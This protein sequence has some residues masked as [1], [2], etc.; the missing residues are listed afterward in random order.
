[1]RLRDVWIRVVNFQPCVGLRSNFTPTFPH[2]ENKLTDLH[3]EIAPGNLLKSEYRTDKNWLSWSFHI[4]GTRWCVFAKRRKLAWR[5]GS[6]CRYC[7]RIIKC[8]ICCYIVCCG[9]V[10]DDARNWKRNWF[11]EWQLPT[12][13][14]N[15]RSDLIFI[16]DEKE[17]VFDTHL[18]PTLITAIG[19]VDYP[20]LLLLPAIFNDTESFCPSRTICREKDEDYNTT[21]WIPPPTFVQTPP[22]GVNLQRCGSCKS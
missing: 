9:V 7:C 14:S 1:M 6:C 20:F 13:F 21:L 11:I 22:Q 15:V 2:T 3:Y 18:L 19:K 4:F 5:P 16:Q 12:C 8:R 17:T 10:A